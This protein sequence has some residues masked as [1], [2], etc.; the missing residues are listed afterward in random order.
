MAQKIVEVVEIPVEFEIKDDTNF[1]Q[2]RT[3]AYGNT[4]KEALEAVIAAINGDN[5]DDANNYLHI[6]ESEV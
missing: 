6:V 3:V 4:Y 5:V 2:F 1:T